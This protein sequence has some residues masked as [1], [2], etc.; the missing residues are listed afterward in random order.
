MFIGELVERML[1][2]CGKAKVH[3][4]GRTAGGVPE[5]SEIIRD[6]KKVLAAKGDEIIRNF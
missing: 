2:V 6:L 4:H 5:Q 1:S 3:L